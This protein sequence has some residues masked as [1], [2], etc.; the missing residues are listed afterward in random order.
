MTFIYTNS[1]L[2]DVM[3]KKA[4]LQLGTKKKKLLGIKLPLK[5]EIYIKGIK[6][7]LSKRQDICP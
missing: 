5:Y 6:E 7:N 1:S 3:R 4:H 2:V